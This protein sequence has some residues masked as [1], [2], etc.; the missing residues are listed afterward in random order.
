MLAASK[1]Q[2]R[3]RRKSLDELGLDDFKKNYPQY[4]LA[5]FFTR[6]EDFFEESKASVWVPALARCK[7]GRPAHIE[8]VHEQG[9]FTTHPLVLEGSRL[10]LNAHTLAGGSIRAELQ[11][12]EGNVFPG[13]SLGDSV[14]FSGD[15]VEAEFRWKESGLEEAF[16]RVVRIR[17]VLD[18]ARLYSFRIGQ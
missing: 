16:R 8:P 11:D 17:V 9:E 12:A 18:K 10:V 15:E 2:A 4:E 3:W 1:D 6:W 5:P 14:P 13:L 7:A